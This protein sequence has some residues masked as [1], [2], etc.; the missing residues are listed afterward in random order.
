MRIATVYF[1]YLGSTKFI[2]FISYYKYRITESCNFLFWFHLYRLLNFTFI[3]FNF[4]KGKEILLLLLLENKTKKNWRGIKIIGHQKICFIYIK[5]LKTTSLPLNTEYRLKRR[6]YT[7]SW[8]SPLKS[9]AWCDI[10]LERK[11]K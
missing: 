3:Y 7:I 11:E 5:S 4:V 6:T 2:F 10:F 9:H 8:D 1:L